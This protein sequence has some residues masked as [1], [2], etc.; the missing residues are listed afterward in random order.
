M[1]KVIYLTAIVLTFW[2][3]TIHP[4]QLQTTTDAPVRLAD[5]GSPILPIQSANWT[6]TDAL[7]RHL[8]TAAETGPFR[9]N[10]YVGIMYYLWHGAYDPKAVY[11]ITKLTRANPTKPAFGPAGAFHWWG[12]PEAG[13]FKADDPWVIRRNLQLLTLAGVDVLF[14]DVTN[15]STY[16]PTVTKLCEISMAMRNDGI[17]TPYICFLTYSKGPE[18]VTQLY[19]QFYA[20][21]RF[22]DLW[23]HWQGKPLILGKIEDMTDLTVRDFFNWR[24]SWA[25]TNS[26]NEPH[27]WQWLDRSPQNYGWDTNPQIPE[28]IPVSVAGHPTLDVG[29]SFRG[30]RQ[31]ALVSGNLTTN[32]NQGLYF[33]E[34]WKRALQVNP[35]LVFVTGWNE[36]IAQRFV[37]QKDGDT[38]F[39]GKDT[40]AG[41]TYFVD[42]YNREFNRDIEP[43][44]DGYTDTYYYQLVG[45]IRRFKGMDAPEPAS[46]AQSVA[47]DGQFAEWAAIKPKFI[48]P[49]GDTFHRNYMSFGDQLRY[50]NNTGRNDI[51]ESRMTHD[52]KNLYVYARTNQPLTASTGRNWMLLFIDADQSSTTG[53]QGYEYVINRAVS[54]KTTS[55]SRWN[56]SSYQKTGTGQLAYSGDGLEIALP[57]SAV[58]QKADRVR[59]DFHWADN[60]QQIGSINEF[61]VNGDS[62]PDRR[63][64]YRYVSK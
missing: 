24:Y 41:Q 59:V 36:W 34:Q 19:Q 17:P 50:V 38:K 39:L 33:E 61:F 12:E 9:H 6:A 8:P 64:N 44:K 53:W 11:D 27:H 10:K 60:I 21:G 20:P 49:R 5:T 45:N 7:G 32:T 48:D 1:T 40:K 47:I 26:R 4:L 25:W 23:F 28:Q 51:I 2:Q 46:P 22:R 43:M 13:Y 15:G 55:I 62:A 14:F 37:S 16:L 3:L 63:F 18:V 42:L 54:G 58:G 35:E 29:K 52:A 31:A 57:L 30:G 56:G